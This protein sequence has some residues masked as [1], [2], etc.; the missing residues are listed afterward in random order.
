MNTEIILYQSRVVADALQ[1]TPLPG[2]RLTF[3]IVNEF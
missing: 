3:P 1:S 2:S